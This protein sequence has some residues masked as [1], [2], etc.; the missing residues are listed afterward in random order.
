MAL[1]TAEQLEALM[2]QPIPGENPGGENVRLESAFESVERE[3][4]KLDS[5]TAEDP[6]RWRD[7][8][9]TSQEILQQQSKDFLVAC[10]LTRALCE[11]HVID[12][13]Q[14]GLAVANGMVEHFWD[15]AY[16]PK[17]RVRGR[18][19][20]F[21]WL[22][23]KSQPLLE[24]YQP[25]IAHLE[26]IKSLEATVIALDNTLVEKMADAAPNLADFR[27]R[28]RRLRQ[29]LEMEQQANVRRVEA[30]RPV[31]TL[32]RETPDS[33]LPRENQ[34]AGT[35]LVM[36]T[37]PGSGSVAAEKDL[38]AIYRAV[39]DPLRSASQFLRNK[40]LTDPEAY[41][42]NRFVTWLGISQLP[43]ATDGKTQLKPVP[44]DKVATCQ[45]LWAE[46]RWQ[47]LLPELENS[48]SRAPY[49]LDGH[50][51]VCEALQSMQAE[52]A[53]AAVMDGVRAFVSRF[54]LVVNYCFSDGT[55]FADEPTRQW[56]NREV[57][58]GRQTAAT[59]GVMVDV[60][61]IAQHWQDTY[62]QA[63]TLG[64]E[65][66]YREALALFQQGCSQ[67]TSLREQS[68]WRFN[69]ARFCVELNLLQL[70]VPLLENLDR[71]LIEKGVDEWEPQITSK[72]L[73]L[74]LRCYRAL[75]IA[76]V[77]E[78]RV[79]ELHARLCKLDL[80]LAFDLSKH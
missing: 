24:K 49:W 31:G 60:S 32:E 53:A 16:P 66:K 69:Q 20:A 67:S 1:L 6:V 71:Q 40:K 61:G 37:V 10:Y 47:E 21:E 56:I 64:K 14:Q 80:A 19:Q 42:I 39:Q 2:V 58:G 54:P 13:L 46:Q 7:V 26:K 76:E 12:G 43:P 4:G 51:W 65:K 75:D 9:A 48:L 59:T 57:N 25:N 18:A 79:E 22:V 8:L 35:V 41:R 30:S 11:T 72:V 73:E 27:Q 3:I 28:F 36:P 23:E 62:E 38:I 78:K 68:L 34:A 33:D 5:L 44:K 15:H 29:G 74:L 55:P 52:D 63:L 70:S 50:R 17:K 45:A 77:P